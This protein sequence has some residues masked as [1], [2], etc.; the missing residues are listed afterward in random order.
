[1]AVRIGI[2]ASRTTR[3]QRTGTEGYSL[4]LL[5][6]L[7]SLDSDNEYTL[8]FNSP[9]PSGLLPVNAN[10]H[11]CLIPLPRLWTHLRL[12]WEMVRRPPD[13]LFVPAHVLPL[14]HPRRT[15]ATIHDLGYYHEPNAHPRRQRM[16]LEWATRFNAESATR[17]IA[18]SQATR[19]DLINVLGIADDKIRVVYLGVD[20]RFRPV[21]DRELTAAVKAKYG[22]A[23]PYV[24][25]VGTLQPRKNL[26]RLVEA[27]GRVAR[28]VD[29]G[30]DGMNP[31]DSTDPQRQLSLVL[32]G[33]KGWWYQDLLRTVEQMD[34]AG[35][36]VAPGYV[37]DDD[38]PVLYSG[39]ELFVLPSL[40]E[41][42][43]LP[44]L[45]AMACG[46][47]VVAAN[48]SSLP[49]IV[50]DA[51]VLAVPTDAGDIAR[52]MIRLLMDPAR[53]ADLRRRGLEQAHRFTWDRCARQTLD[54][55]VDVATTA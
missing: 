22:I 50:G 20:E 15:V 47:P 27:F 6:S 46:T 3:P 36:V 51:G 32:A 39:A 13:V 17:V 18:D 25:F 44:V 41:G 37:N 19:R 55:L 54:V 9:P 33:G 8:Y 52:A 23:G 24:L 7:L 1:M 21:V 48:V 53:A 11:S 26:M 12:S 38:L 2:D 5:R 30:Y 43:G 45:E 4:A 35:R 31:Y 28:A 10:T 14:V 29:A 49:E 40:Y 42:F 34:L 16:Y